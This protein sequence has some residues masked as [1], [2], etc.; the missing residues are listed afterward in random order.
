MPRHEYPAALLPLPPSRP[1]QDVT[2]NATGTPWLRSW[3]ILL[4]VVDAD[5]GEHHREH[6]QRGEHDAEDHAGNRRPLISTP[7]PRRGATR[8]PGSG[9]PSGRCG[10]HGASGQCA[11]RLR[12]GHGGMLVGGRDRAIVVVAG[13]GAPSSARA[14]NDR[15][16][17]VGCPQGVD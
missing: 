14:R 11:R 9:V 1:W 15:L 7:A 5:D 17:Q 16:N 6:R 8:R 12:R 13:N 2:V 4:V 3:S 10:R